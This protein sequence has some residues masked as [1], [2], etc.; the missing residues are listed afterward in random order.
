R[1]PGSHRRAWQGRGFL[2]E[3][4][5]G[6]C[7]SAS[8]LNTA[9]SAS[10]PSRL[11]RNQLAGQALQHGRVSAGVHR[12]AVWL[13]PVRNWGAP[14]NTCDDLSIRSVAKRS[15]KPDINPTR[16]ATK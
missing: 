12:L 3:R 15:L 9:Y 14:E 1:H 10:I 4:W 11:R 2:E 7:T 13:E 6:M 5:L 16:E 8:S